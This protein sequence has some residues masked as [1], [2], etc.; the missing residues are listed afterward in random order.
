[1]DFNG[2]K[3]IWKMGTLMIRVGCCSYGFVLRR[4]SSNARSRDRSAFHGKGA[5][6]G[7]TPAISVLARISLFQVKADFSWTS[8][9]RKPRSF[10]VQFA[11]SSWRRF[12]SEAAAGA[13]RQ[14]FPT[15]GEVRYSALVP[16]AALTLLSRRRMIGLK[17]AVI[18][19]E[20]IRSQHKP[21]L[22]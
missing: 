16:L 20:Y 5:F 10:R 7:T 9:P 6:F 2:N 19:P 17:R 21:R 1:M 15:V 14:L 13:R 3:K 18:I 12:E 11:W 22:Q 8:R 4:S